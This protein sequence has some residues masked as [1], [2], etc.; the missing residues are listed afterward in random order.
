MLTNV[1]GN[2]RTSRVTSIDG[3]I[4]QFNDGQVV[5]TSLGAA[6]KTDRGTF[7]PPY[8][9]APVEFQVGKSWSGRSTQ[10]AMDGQVFELQQTAK[11]VGRETITVPAGTFQTYVIETVAYFS[12][13]TQRIKLW[14]DPRYGFP[15]KK[16]EVVRTQWRIVRSDRTELAAI[17]AERS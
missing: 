15:I 14:M 5:L 13:R 8:G 17:R 12:G 11:I 9:G 6:I 3:D 7:D 1:Q 4:V 16:E 10:H 2:R